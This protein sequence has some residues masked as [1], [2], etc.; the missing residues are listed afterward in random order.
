MGWALFEVQRFGEDGEKRLFCFTFLF[1][2]F[3]SVSILS[4]IE[5]CPEPLWEGLPI[6][7]LNK[8]IHKIK[9]VFSNHLNFVFSR[10]FL[11]LATPPLSTKYPVTLA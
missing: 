1:L 2:L 11:S 9:S 10:C 7:L 4:F 5:R 6:N 3:Y 8:Y